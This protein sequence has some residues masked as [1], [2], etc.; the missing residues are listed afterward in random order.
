MI[1]ATT[2]TYNG[3][4]FNRFV[5][6]S[7]YM[8]SVV[9]GDRIT[10]R[11]TRDPLP[12]QNGIQRYID[13]YGSRLLEIKGFIKGSSETDLYDKIGSLQAAFDIGNLEDVGLAGFQALDWTDPGQSPAR[14]YVKPLNNTLVVQEKRTGLA[15]E[16]SVLLEAKDPTKYSST[17]STLTLTVVSTGGTGSSHPFVFPVIF[18]SASGYVEGTIINTG[19]TAVYPSSIVLTGPASGTWT[20]PKV[21]NI[22]TGESIQFTSSVTLAVGETIT[23]SPAAGTVTKTTSGGTSTDLSAYLISSSIYWQVQS[24][25]NTIRLE[26]SSLPLGSSALITVVNSYS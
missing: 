21:T 1:L 8:A 10:I 7:G 4:T 20:A 12:S 2:I 26:G 24:G 3:I 9:T 23:I 11:S 13:K 16:F 22:T 15:R 6:T 25:S 14:Y 5:R 18:S 19:S 17:T